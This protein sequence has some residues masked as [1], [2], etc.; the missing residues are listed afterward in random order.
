MIT[1]ESKNSSGQ[2]IIYFDG[3]CPMC[4]AL[5]SKIENSE[6]KLNFEQKD[7]NT[8]SLPE[9]LTKDQVLKEIHVVTSDGVIYRNSEAIIKILEQYPKL[10][11]LATFGKL[12]IVR[13]ILPIGYGIVA[14]NRHFIF[15][16]ASRVFWVKIILT[17]ATLSSLLLS[18]KLWAGD[19]LF[20]KIPVVSSFF[21]SP[22]IIEN[23]IYFAVILLLFAIFFSSK[24]RKFIF[25]LLT[26]FIF[27]VFV[28]QMRLQPW[29]YQFFFMFLV[30]GFYS[31]DYNDSLGRLKVLNTIRLIMASIYFYSGL[32][33]INVLFIGGVFPWMISPIISYFPPS[34]Q[35]LAISTGIFV[36][37]IEIGIG[38]GLLTKK[39]RR[40]AV[41]FAVFTHLFILFLLSPL[42]KNW[43]SVVW[44]WNIA[45]IFFVIA[46]FWRTDNFSFRDTFFVKDYFVNK[47][48]IVL[49][50]IMPFFSFFNFWDS[51]LSFALYS[52][53]TN[54]AN[55]YI[56]ES[57][58]QNLPEKIRTHTIAHKDGVHE[59]DFFNWSF[60]ELNVPTYPED[61]IYKSLTKSFCKYDNTGYNIALFIK[62]RPS[63]FN[64]EE[65]MLYYCADL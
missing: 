32:Q 44:P 48:A 34:I 5:T 31:W 63:W 64:R 14:A 20:P 57:V 15:G 37:F 58:K 16:E 52:G 29:L 27:L 53:N 51:Y 41:Y 25:S 61:R 2:T 30:L 42:V 1:N 23:L 17:L 18:F 13:N 45:M 33:K 11:F 4:T 56:N 9:G 3:G 47:L 54:S 26:I 62:G 43:N 60:I 12:P 24:P 6:Q 8:S 35:N 55:I 22:Q 65:G 28:D 10:K 36:P 50:V 21:K 19:R 49:F 7:I 59:I 46:L 40:Y 39:Y 38:V